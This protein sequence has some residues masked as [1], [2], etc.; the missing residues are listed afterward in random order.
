MK[1]YKIKTIL[2]T[3]SGRMPGVTKLVF[4]LWF[5][6]I[7]RGKLSAVNA[8]HDFSVR[9]RTGSNPADNNRFGSQSQSHSGNDFEKFN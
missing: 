5:L 8:I 2:S 9:P 3:P 1:K 4:I 7:I 6:F